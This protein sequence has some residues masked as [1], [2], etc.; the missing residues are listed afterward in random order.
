MNVLEVSK[1]Y[2]PE[3]GG[4]ESVVRTAA[5]GVAERGH[6]V[7]VLATVPQGRGH[8]HTVSD[9]PV[10]KTSSL[11]QVLS[12]PLTPTFPLRLRRA[13]RSADVVH[14]HIPNPVTVASHFVA[15]PDAPTV[16][17]YHSDIVRQSGA[18]RAY[19]PLLERF[20]EAVDRI[21]VTSPRLLDHSEVLG[22]YR[23]KCRVVP[24]SVDT[25]TFGPPGSAAEAPSMDIDGPVLLFVGKLRY[26]K[27]VEYL[28][29]AMAEIDATLVV[30][31]E[32]E[33]RDALETAAQE[34]GVSERVRFL[35]HVSE[36][37]LHS[38]YDAADLFVLPSVE[39]SEAFGV[40]QLEAMAYGTPVV[41]TDLPTGVPWVSKD[42]ETGLTVPPRDSAALA[43][44]ITNLLD[45]DER[46][47]T[48]GRAARKRVESTFTQEAR[49]D[50][51]IECFTERLA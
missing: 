29:E 3:Y 45:D 30:V 32:G 44:A 43:T 1:F 46:R 51:L 22:P 41:N 11:G 34:T 27:G 8:S 36:A 37:Q 2:Y 21:L 50:A 47:A 18:L 33:R 24:L 31:G 17:T 25:S 5:E 26:Y 10:T 40:V 28:V 9:I 7:R 19:R 49:I 14:Y 6:D 38:W 15:R 16:A 12:V 4:L 13:V 23:E 42:G 35:G 20:L 48:Y 39:P